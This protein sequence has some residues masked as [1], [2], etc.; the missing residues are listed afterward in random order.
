MALEK[1]LTSNDLWEPCPFGLQIYIKHLFYNMY[2]RF[3][4]SN[5]IYLS[6]LY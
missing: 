3:S 2:L 6:F 1:Y 4:L 5:D